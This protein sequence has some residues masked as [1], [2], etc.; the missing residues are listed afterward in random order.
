MSSTQ[1]THLED[2]YFERMARATEEKTALIPHLVPGTVADVGA[3]GGQLAMRMAQDPRISEVWAIDDSVDAVRRLGEHTS[4]ST[5]YGSTERLACV[6]PV[7]NVVFSSVLHEVYSY[8][9]EG[10][11]RRLAWR[12]ALKHAVDAL[13][14]GGRIVVRDFVS[15][16]RPEA[17]ALLEAPDDAA[18][19]LVREYLERIPEHLALTIG[20]LAEMGDREFVGTRAAVA[21]ALLTVCWG[22][23]SLPRES[24]ERY[25]LGTLQGYA[26]DVLALDDRLSLVEAASEVQPGY[27]EH[28]AG[29]T[30]HDLPGDRWFPD[31]KALWVFQKEGGRP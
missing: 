9:E 22:Q 20:E 10:L 31:T 23:G 15:P 25:C 24:K 26:A 13:A 3:G 1:R 4:F 6:A 18:A 16:D 5:L 2:R 12:R 19:A 11:P 21:E 7:D 30:C 27:V 29:W 14:P 8:A 28:L 17:M